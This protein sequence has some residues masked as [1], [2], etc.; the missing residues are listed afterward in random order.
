[1]VER[2]LKIEELEFDKNIY[3]RIET[4]WLTVHQY[5][6]AMKAGAIFP[7][8]IVG[9]YKGKKYLIDGWHRVLACKRNNEEYVKAIVKHYKSEKEMFFDAVKANATHG[10]PLSVQEKARIIDKL[11]EYGFK[12]QEI[13]E[14]L[15]IPISKIERFQIRVIRHT[16][17]GEKIYLKAPLAKEASEKILEMPAEIIEEAQELLSVNSQI[18]LLKQ[19]I[20]LVKNNLL[21]IENQK[22]KAL[23]EEL[24]ALLK[25]KMKINL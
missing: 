21:A 15:R 10:R 16:I 9:I 8:A 3:P 20:N 1:M 6:E 5:A 2:I 24:I 17:S 14:V 23:V 25:E 7:P 13:S 18:M 12:R 22:V 11:I 19:L 4:N